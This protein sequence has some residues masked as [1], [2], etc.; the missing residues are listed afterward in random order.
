MLV[1][2]LNKDIIVIKE[3][4]KVKVKVIGIMDFNIDLV[5]LD[6]GIL[7]NDDFVKLIILIFIVL[8]DVIVIVKGG[9][10]LFVY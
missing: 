3:V 1:V 2:D 6:F 7:V 9:K 8:V 4:K 5:L 10:V